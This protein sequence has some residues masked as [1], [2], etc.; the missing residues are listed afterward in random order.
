MLKEYEEQNQNYISPTTWRKII[1]YA[2]LPMNIAVAFQA[3]KLIRSNQAMATNNYGL[4]QH[5]GILSIPLLATAK[6][7]PLAINDFFYNLFGIDWVFNDIQTINYLIHLP[8]FSYTDNSKK[9]EIRHNNTIQK[10]YKN[11]TQDLG[12][13]Y[14][15]PEEDVDENDD[16]EY[17]ANSHLPLDEE[18]IEWLFTAGEKNDHTYDIQ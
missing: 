15:T 8:T 16:D 18:E 4:F 17:S 5:I 3:S 12:Q 2:V 13:E 9:T 1:N 14:P 6:Q 10:S 11:N 7:W